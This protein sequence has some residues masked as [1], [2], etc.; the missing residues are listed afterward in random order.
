MPGDILHE[1]GEN[2]E[3]ENMVSN[4]PLLFAGGYPTSLDK[5][6][7][8]QL[9]KFIP[10]MVQCSLGEIQSPMLDSNSEPEWWPED[11]RFTI[12]LKR[13]DDFT[14][15]WLNKLKE[16]VAIC[17]QFH[18]SVFLLRFCE[19][20]SAYT[21]ESLRF[22][23]NYNSTTSLFDR[24]SNKLLVTFRNENML[25]DQPVNNKK[26]LMPKM[27]N[28][29]SGESHQMVEQSL[30]DI[31]LCD[32][33][34]A[35]LYSLGA[36]QEHEKTCQCHDDDD[37]IFCDEEE[38]E[39]PIDKT[40]QQNSFL[41]HFQ[42]CKNIPADEKKPIKALTPNKRT[43]QNALMNINSKNTILNNNNCVNTIDL[44][45]NK[46]AVKRVRTPAAINALLKSQIPITSPA[47]QRLIAQSNAPINSDYIRER[48]ERYERS[49]AAPPLAIDGS[50]RPKFMDKKPIIYNISSFRNTVKPFHCYKFPRRQLSTKMRN[51]AVIQLERIQL[52]QSKCKPLAITVERL[53]NKEIESIKTQVSTHKRP[54]FND[55]IVID[56][57]D[58]DGNDGDDGD[59]DDDNDD[60]SMG[61]LTEVSHE[62][63]VTSGLSS[64]QKYSTMAP[65]YQPAH[66]IPTNPL[67]N[68]LLFVDCSV[69]TQN[70]LNNES[71][72][73]DSR[74]QLTTSRTQCDSASN[75]LDRKPIKSHHSKLYETTHRTVNLQQQLQQDKENRIYSYLT[76]Q[77]NNPQ[78]AAF[79]Y[80]D[81]LNMN[82]DSTIV[83]ATLSSNNLISIDLTL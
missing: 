53:S 51:E 40:T 42:L 74:P 16:I 29:Q 27:Q 32:N 68:T 30:F 13:P 76:E 1:L 6:S 56:S 5:I 64:R 75:L 59:D 49:C 26:T 70:Y 61:S 31:Y 44:E 55:V 58:D 79:I 17:Y 18:K 24:R 20:L 4:L 12:P 69:P 66:S 81:D 57:S 77:S 14:D 60:K 7:E 33:C 9:E 48:I 46:K 34:D 19:N 36:Y 72:M 35:E 38:P 43:S 15:S 47:G 8:S 23:N 25:Y 52:Q 10:F 80:A 82:I 11:V 65:F 67:H 78:S 3:N 22:I 21:A 63:S 50:N 62:T 71:I 37:V 28:S 83:P 2:D 41:Q 45:P 54:K 39:N 73:F